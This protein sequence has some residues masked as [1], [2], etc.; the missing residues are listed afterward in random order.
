RRVDVARGGHAAPSRSQPAAR[1]RAAGSLE[2]AKATA[3]FVAAALSRVPAESA[4][5]GEIIAVAG[6]DEVTIGETLADA[7]DPRPL[8]VLHIDE[9]SLSMTIGVNTAHL[10]RQGGGTKL[11]AGRVKGRR[12]AELGGN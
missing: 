1:C 3:L 12:V 8:P 7:A 9:P 6:L 5:P 2:R 4:G 10:A 11:P